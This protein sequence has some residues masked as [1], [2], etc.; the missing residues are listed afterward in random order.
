MTSPV[1]GSEGGGRRPYDVPNVCAKTLIHANVTTATTTAKTS[2]K[3]KQARGVL[4]TTTAEKISERQI[5]GKTPWPKPPEDLARL[6]DARH[7]VWQQRSTSWTATQ[8]RMLWLAAEADPAQAFRRAAATVSATTRATYWAAWMS[9]L[10]VLNRPVTASDSAYLKELERAAR[11]ARV[12]HPAPMLQADVHKVTERDHSPAAVLIG[13][14]WTLGQR[15]SDL[16]Q[17]ECADITVAD[18][19][20]RVVLRRGKVIPRVGPYAVA[21]PSDNRHMRRLMDLKG[22]RIGK[23]FLFAE[24][25]GATTTVLNQVARILR[26]SRRGLELRSIRR[27]GLQALAACNPLSTVLTFS[28]HASTSMLMRYLENGVACGP[29]VKEMCAAVART[30]QP[31]RQC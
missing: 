5:P 14:A 17:I 30:A 12:T 6:W 15:V 25:N 10:P 24:D 29:H 21:G 28:K 1:E 11:C 19:A 31:T 3:M 4:S 8:R 22:R 20:V 7:E 2:V 26:S 13:A 18:G 16:A 27:G 9:V 23:Q